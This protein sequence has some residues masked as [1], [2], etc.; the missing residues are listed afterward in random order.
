MINFESPQSVIIPKGALLDT[1]I[2]WNAIEPLILHSLPANKRI[3]IID[4]FLSGF[5]PMVNKVDGFNAPLSNLQPNSIL[6]INITYSLL[7]F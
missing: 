5:L 1:L 6:S 3:Y 2:G 7:F 4:N